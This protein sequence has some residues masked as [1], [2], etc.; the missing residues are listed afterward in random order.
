MSAVSS[1]SEDPYYVSKGIGA[2]RQVHFNFTMTGK[3]VYDL[4]QFFE[5]LALESKGRS[6]DHVRSCVLWS[7]KF[8]AEARTQGF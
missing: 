5:H 1:T 3:E 7:E 4:L 6:Y 8:R 2:N